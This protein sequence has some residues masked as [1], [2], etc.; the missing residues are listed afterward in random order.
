MSELARRALVIG[1]GVAGLSAL[2][3]L[4]AAGARPLL[5]ERHRLGHS[6]GSSHGAARIAR[7]S[8]GDP[9]YARLMRIALAEDWPRLERRASRTL[10]WR[11]DMCLSGPADG[12]FESYARAVLESGVEVERIDAC[13]ARRR[14]PELRLDEA[15]GALHDRTAAVIDAAGTLQALAREARA[16]GAEILEETRCTALELG[17]DP[18]RVH[19]ER[20]HFLAER[21]VVTAGAWS[22]G[23]VPE[24]ERQTRVLQQCVGYFRYAGPSRLGEFAP[25]AWLGAGPNGIQ[26]GLPAFGGE[27]L[28]VARHRTSGEP[29]DPDAAGDARSAERELR[30]L[31]AGASRILRAEL[32]PCLRSER[33]LYTMRPR[34]DFA[35]ALHPRDPRVVIGAGFSGHGFKFAPLIGRALAGLALHGRSGIREIDS[36]SER[37]G[38]PVGRNSAPPA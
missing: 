1:G 17:C 36:E 38:L 4:A 3:E 32:G 9:L 20:G 18:L 30:E 34:E 35:L 14:F 15:T 25:W 16:L 19:T 27:G 5:L 28:K 21:L 31:H 23:L 37:F 11:A 33:C 12:P 24:L 10:L 26:Y 13:E 8:Y 29:V 7:S 2:C 6:H 22:A